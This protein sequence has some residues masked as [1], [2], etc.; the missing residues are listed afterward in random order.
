M[1]LETEARDFESQIGYFP[2]APEKFK[3]FSAGI[4]SYQIVTDSINFMDSYYN[5][6]G[7]RSIHL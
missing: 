1:K 2:P 5:T 3:L 7:S 6:L 4:Y